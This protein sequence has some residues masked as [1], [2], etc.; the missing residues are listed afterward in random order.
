M[1]R[2]SLLTNHLCASLWLVFPCLSAFSPILWSQVH[3][4]MHLYVHP[5]PL[6]Q[7]QHLPLSDLPQPRILAG[8]EGGAQPP[9]KHETTSDTSAFQKGVHLI[10]FQDY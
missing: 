9:P 5:T 2:T 7:L 3:V 4:Y 1:M 8:R 6:S 10:K